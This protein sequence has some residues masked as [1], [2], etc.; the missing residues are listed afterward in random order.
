MNRWHTT[1][2]VRAF[3][4]STRIASS[5][6]YT[7]T[8]IQTL[9]VRC[10]IIR[11]GLIF[12][13]GELTLST[14]VLSKLRFEKRNGYLAF[15]HLLSGTSLDCLRPCSSPS[16]SP[17]QSQYF[18]HYNL[19]FCGIASSCTTDEVQDVLG[20]YQHPLLAINYEIGHIHR[21]NVKDRFSPHLSLPVGVEPSL[22]TPRSSS[23]AIDGGHGNK[24]RA[25]RGQIAQLSTQC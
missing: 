9:D 15:N 6:S 5:S 17:T 19:T 14:A 2:C 16:I 18:S 4:S 7:H 10:D 13:C 3:L 21:M 20:V 8:R 22:M 23:V 1:C 11:E 12:S 25:R 24:K